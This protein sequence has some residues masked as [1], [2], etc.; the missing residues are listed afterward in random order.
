MN[1]TTRLKLKEAKANAEK[2]IEQ[3]KGMDDKKLSKHIEL[4]RQQME[5]AYKKGDTA[6]IEL[7]TEYE[8]QT[9]VAR[10]EKNK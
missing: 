6:A 3:M 8:W 9:I 2:F 1:R 5:I 4:F 10:V 7:L